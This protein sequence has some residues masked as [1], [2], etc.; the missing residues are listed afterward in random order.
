MPLWPSRTP[1]M[2]QSQASP[3]TQG[4]NLPSKA[5][6]NRHQ[7]EPVQ[8]TTYSKTSQEQQLQK[9]QD[10]QQ[11]Q[12]LKS[13]FERKRDSKPA[14]TPIES[15]LKEP[16]R[17]QPWTDLCVRLRRDSP[18]SLP[19][20]DG[21]S[22]D[23]DLLLSSSSTVSYAGSESSLEASPLHS[24]TFLPGSKSSSSSS[25]RPENTA[26]SIVTGPGVSEARRE[27]VIFSFVDY[28]RS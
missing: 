7:G 8:K 17:E 23:L 16:V 27:T 3:S 21:L 18:Q 25:S 15:W 6:N 24:Y 4:N 19:E 28:S 1:Q 9:S 20:L 11:K 22:R 14:V 13:H 26:S 5:A 12:Q 2:S 10:N